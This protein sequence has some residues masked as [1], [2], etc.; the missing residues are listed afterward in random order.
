[1]NKKGATLI[2][3]LVGLTLVSFLVLTIYLALAKTVASIGESKQRVGAIA[4][5]NEKMEV[6]RNLEYNEVGVIDGIVSGPM[7]AFETVIRNNFEYQVYIDVRYIDDEFDG[8]GVD[9]LIPTD[10]KFVEV[11]VY[12]NH[13]GKTKSIQ[14]NS[15]F[16]PNGIETNM[17]GGTLVLNALTSGGENVSNVTVN[18]TSIE[19]NPKVNYT[20]VTDNLGSLVLQGVPSQNYRI[21]LSKNGYETVRTYPNPPESLFVPINTDFYVSEGDLNSKNFLIDPVSDLKIKTID[22]ITREPISGIEIN[23]T[24]GKE[25]G[26]TP[27]TYNLNDTSDTNYSGEI[28]YSEISSGLY[29]IVNR[30]TIGIG[31]Y[32]YVG[33][34]EAFIFNLDAGIEKELELIFSDKSESALLLSVFEPVN[35]NPLKDAVVVVMGPNDFNQSVTTDESGVAFFPINSDPIVLMENSN[36]TVEIRIPGYQDHISSIS[37]N[38]LTKEEITLNPI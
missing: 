2:E 33:S 31:D 23:L 37:I 5:A 28:N 26:S 4:I 10:Y 30:G 1:M 16:V 25:I 12:W 14:F 6:M 32:E 24:G 9:D 21:T 38:N 7:L 36:Y 13:L 15:N 29:E 3:V 8:T 18:L 19:N 34:S 20:A 27:T 17:G 35:E 22:A 11:V